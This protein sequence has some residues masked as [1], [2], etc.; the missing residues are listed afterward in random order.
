MKSLPRKC[1]RHID[2]LRTLIKN[3]K[4]FNYHWIDENLVKLMQISDVTY[5]LIFINRRT[6]HTSFAIDRSRPFLF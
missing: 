4:Y 3:N 1:T 5:G 2:A 6:R